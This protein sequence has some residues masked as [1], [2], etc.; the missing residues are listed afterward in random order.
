MKRRALYPY[1]V[2]LVHS[3]T[4]VHTTTLPLALYMEFIPLLPGCRSTPQ[5]C[6]PPLP[7]SL[8]HLQDNSDT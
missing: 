2:A 4:P 3:C 7:A 1:L 6:R 8:T 5:C